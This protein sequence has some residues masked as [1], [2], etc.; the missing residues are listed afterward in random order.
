MRATGSIDI[1]CKF[2]PWLDRVSAKAERVQTGLKLAACEARKQQTPLRG[3]LCD[4]ADGGAAPPWL[5][6]ILMSLV[7]DFKTK[8]NTDAEACRE[9]AMVMDAFVYLLEVHGGIDVEVDDETAWPDVSLRSFPMVL[10]AMHAYA[11]GNRCR[12]MLDPRGVDG[13]GRQCGEQVERWNA[14]VMAFVA[15]VARAGMEETKNIVA[16]VMRTHQIAKMQHP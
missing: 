14:I 7:K 1:A 12:L 11:H 16:T 10:D 4:A 3:L 5:H 2:L 6:M 13:A 9:V 8:S 15:R